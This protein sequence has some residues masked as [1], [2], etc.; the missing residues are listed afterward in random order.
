MDGDP[1]GNFGID[2]MAILKRIREDVNCIRVIQGIG[3]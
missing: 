3:Q 1:P 2:G